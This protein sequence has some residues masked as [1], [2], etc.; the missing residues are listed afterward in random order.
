MV[1]FIHPGQQEPHTQF[2][3]FYLRICVQC[4]IY[5]STVYDVLDGIAHLESYLESRIYFIIR[6]CCSLAEVD[7]HNSKILNHV[8]SLI[9]ANNI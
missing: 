8:F 6:Q 7:Q 5:R 1:V 2:W 3:A 4:A 9:H